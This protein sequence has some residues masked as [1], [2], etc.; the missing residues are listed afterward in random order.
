MFCTGSGSLSPSLL[1]NL[2]DG[3]IWSGLMFLLF[4]I[5]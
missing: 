5:K 4:V 1:K 3:V 2:C